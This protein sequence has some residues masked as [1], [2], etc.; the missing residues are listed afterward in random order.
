MLEVVPEDHPVF[1]TEALVNI[2]TVGKYMT[3]VMFEMFNVLTTSVAIRFVLSL[4]VNSQKYN[5]GRLGSA[6]GGSGLPSGGSGLPRSGSGLP[7]GGSGLP[8]GGSGLS[9]NCMGSGTM[10]LCKIVG[11]TVVL[12]HR[13]S[14][15]SEINPFSV[16]WLTVG[17]DHG[18]RYNS[19]CG[20]VVF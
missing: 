10:C 12:M 18:E 9:R 5:Q 14:T 20:S 4:F 1:L 8:R 2:K 19:H 7:R 3:Q 13:V 17:F 6:Q 16:D 15:V 11:V